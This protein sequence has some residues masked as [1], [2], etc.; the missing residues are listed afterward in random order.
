MA[1]VPEGRYTALATR[2]WASG[3]PQQEE[4]MLKLSVQGESAQPCRLGETWALGCNRGSKRKGREK[5]ILGRYS[6]VAVGGQK[7]RLELAL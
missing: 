7:R 6:Y 5:G 1:P 4:S 3:D 2:V